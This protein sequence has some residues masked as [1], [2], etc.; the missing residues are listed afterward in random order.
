MYDGFRCYDQWKT[1]SP[2]DDEP[3][4][5]EEADRWKQEAQHWLT[6]NA[7]T[8]TDEPSAEYQII[9]GLMEYLKAEGLA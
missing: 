6:K 7:P 1:A 3:D 5:I 2:Y 8:T 4:W 9:F